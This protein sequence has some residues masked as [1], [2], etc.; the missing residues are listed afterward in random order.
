M[1]FGRSQKWGCWRAPWSLVAPAAANGCSLCS[2]F[3]AALPI[4]FLRREA[5]FQLPCLVSQ[6]RQNFGF[7][8][9][10]AYNYSCVDPCFPPESSSREIPGLFL[11]RLTCIL[12]GPP[13]FPVAKGE[14]RPRATRTSGAVTTL[15]ARQFFRE[16]KG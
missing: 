15:F 9:A 13:F 4:N 2:S 1:N 8:V 14:L 12:R 11:I 16:A 6:R 10:T 5:T 3:L 7:I